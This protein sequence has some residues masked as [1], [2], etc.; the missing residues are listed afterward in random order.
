MRG[1]RKAIVTFDEPIVVDPGR[2]KKEATATLTKLLEQR[3]QTL[4]DKTE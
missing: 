1:T 3:V 2:D 4:L